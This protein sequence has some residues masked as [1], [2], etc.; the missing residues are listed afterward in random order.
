MRELHPL[1][2][3]LIDP[4]RPLFGVGI[5]AADVSVSQ[6][7]AQ[8]ENE[9]GRTGNGQIAG[10]DQGKCCEAPKAVRPSSTF[11]HIHSCDSDPGVDGHHT[12]MGKAIPKKALHLLF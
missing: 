1:R 2:R 10:R 6:V 7:I 3:H 4:R 12:A 8:N 9:V 5:E 11:H